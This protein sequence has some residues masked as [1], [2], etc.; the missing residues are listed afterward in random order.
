M[1]RSS[2]DLTVDGLNAID[3]ILREGIGAGVA[4]SVVGIH[5]GTRVSGVSEPQG[6][7]KFMGGNK[8]QIVI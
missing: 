2:S 3:V 6:V 7:A 5:Q 4:E 8:K 1:C